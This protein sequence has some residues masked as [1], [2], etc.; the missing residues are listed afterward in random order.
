MAQRKNIELVS[1]PRDAR[2]IAI[3]LDPDTESKLLDAAARQDVALSTL[4]RMLVYGAVQRNHAAVY[5]LLN[6]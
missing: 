2:A 5:R 6:L 1:A 4:V 3:R